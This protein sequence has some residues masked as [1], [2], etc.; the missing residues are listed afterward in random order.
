MG[1]TQKI[2]GLALVVLAL[3]LGAYAWILSSRMAAEQKAAQPKMLPVV[4]AQVRI[5]ADTE[6]SPEMVKTSLFPSRPDGAFSDLN[7][8]IGKVASADIAAGEPLLQERLGGGLRAM[9]QHIAADERAVA[10]HVD[11]VIGVGNRLLPG[12]IV[13]VFFTLRRNG[14][15]IANTQSRLL[16]E[17]LPVLAFGSKDVGAM[18]GGSA[19]VGGKVPVSGGAASRSAEM[20]KTAVLAVKVPDIDKLVLASESGRLILALRP[21]EQPQGAE[22]LVT[23]A[24]DAAKPG[25]APAAPAAVVPAAVAVVAPPAPLTLTQLIAMTEKT[26]P[27]VQSQAGAKTGKRGRSS[28]TA[29]VIV[30]H[31]LKEKTVRVATSGT[32]P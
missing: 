7:S 24:T 19:A 20:P 9:L 26:A 3:L 4:V 12:D 32:R 5:P 2:V 13:D 23:P 11:E 15:E 28:Q 10:I 31:G 17:K 30:M 8:V 22:V 16:L 14:T 21:H 18:A 1:K 29:T 27:P 25:V 6:V